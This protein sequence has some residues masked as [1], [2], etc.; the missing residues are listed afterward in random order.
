M[1]RDLKL[2]I[3]FHLDYQ[4][5]D[6]VK[7]FNVLF[8]CK[9]NRLG[10]MLEFLEIYSDARVNI[11]FKNWDEGIVSSILKAAKNAYVILGVEQLKY[12]EWLK[13]KW[14]RFFVNKD[15]GA[16]NYESLDFLINLGVSDI[17]I[18]D[19]LWYD[20]PKTHEICDNHDINIRLILNRVPST[21]PDR[22]V[23]PKAPIFVPQMFK[24]LDTFVDMFEFDL[25]EKPNWNYCDILYKYWFNSKQWFGQLYEINEDIQ[26]DYPVSSTFSEL[27]MFKLTC[28]KRC[29]SSVNSKCNKC[30]QFLDIARTFRDKNVRINEN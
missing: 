2:A 30:N 13:E 3:P 25:G 28:G 17:Y 1:L 8:D 4:L 24:Y 10:K 20:L 27:A 12:A 7:E 11:Y 23:N 6:R 14:Y 16:Y 19:D 18:L 29:V 21:M 15:L 5:N 22:G 9:V 26:I